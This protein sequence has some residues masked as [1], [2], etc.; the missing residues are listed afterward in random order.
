M[1][2]YVRMNGSENV[3]VSG[4]P[5]NKQAVAF[6]DL[7]A[8]D[9]V[10]LPTT[11]E[12]APSVNP[13]RADQ[14]VD[15]NVSDISE[16]GFNIYRSNLFPAGTTEW[17]ANLIISGT[18][19]VSS[20]A[21]SLTES[22]DM[23][24]WYLNDRKGNNQPIWFDE[25]FKTMLLQQGQELF[26]ELVDENMI[27]TLWVSE[28]ALALGSS[29]EYS[30]LNLANTIWDIERGIRSIKITGHI[31]NARLIP[32]SAYIQGL[33][34]NVNRLDSEVIYYP[35]G[36][37]IY[38]DPYDTGDTVDI[39]YLR[40]PQVINFDTTNSAN[41]V[42]CEFGHKEH[43]IILG[44]ALRDYVDMTPQAMRL[45]QNAILTLQHFKKKRSSDD[46]KRGTGR[47]IIT[48]FSTVTGRHNIYTDN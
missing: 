26:M 8:I 21:F 30:L 13:Q 41:Y 31:Y 5:I 27:N 22:L 39:V 2:Y 24:S 42:G 45:Y 15:F 25:K 20:K 23:M 46:A 33:N 38:L 28:T 36:N 29:G 44:L 34:D 47:G 18:P 40:Q 7:E 1:D 17:A 35:I 19:A 48:D 11:F 9:G 12:S 16:T 37:D 43:N 10:D 4:K 14:D 3:I 6:D 32:H